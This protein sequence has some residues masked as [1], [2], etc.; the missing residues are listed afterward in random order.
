MHLSE[1]VLPTYGTVGAVEQLGASPRGGLKYVSGGMLLPEQT[2]GGMNK[3]MSHVESWHCTCA[4][5]GECLSPLGV[6]ASPIKH[7]FV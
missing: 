5:Q 1:N 2:T 4:A 3:Y 7:N 6:A